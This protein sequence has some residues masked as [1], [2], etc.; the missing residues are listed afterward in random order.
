MKNLKR[1]LSLAL[2]GVMLS[3]MMVMGASAADFTD[4]DE[5][6]NANAVDTMVA[7][8]I[9]NGKDTGDFDPEGL[10][11][12]AEMAKM[13]TIALN[14]GID[15]VL[16]TK[17]TPTYTDIKGH[18]AEKYIEY[19]S[20]LGIINGRGN[21]AFDPA[22]TVTGTEAAKMVLVAMGYDSTVFK[23]TGADWAINVNT[24]ASN[25]TPYKLYEGIE[26][27]DPNAGLSRDNAAQII[28]NGVQ[29]YVMEKSPSLTIQNGQITYNYYKADGSNGSVAKTI[30]S[31]KYGASTWVGTYVGN[32]KTGDITTASAAKG[33]I[34]V[35]GWLNGITTNS[36]GTD[37]PADE[38]AFPSDMD[39]ANIGEEVKVIFKDSRNGKRNAPDK[40]DT[41]YGV[42]NTGATEVLNVTKGDIQ[43]NKAAEKK[44]KVDGTKY[45]LADTVTVYTN[46]AKKAVYTK[47]DKTNTIQGVKDKSN[48]KLTEN[49]MDKT[50]DTIKF[51]MND[52]GKIFA[53][54]VVESKLGVVTAKNSTKVTVN[55]VGTLT[56]ADH[57]IYD[58]IAVDDV[59]VTTVL[60]KTSATTDGAL[61]IVEEA[62][63]AT[64]DVDRYKDQTSVTIDGTVYKVY[65]GTDMTTTNLGSKAV[66]AFEGKH[67]GET[68]DLYLVNGYVAAAVQTSESASNYSLI[69]DKPDDGKTGSVFDNLRLQV[70]GADNVKTI[71]TVS[72]DSDLKTVGEYNIGDIITYTIDKSGE[73]VVTVESSV[74]T[75][76]TASYLK[77]TKA[78]N[79]T[80][81]ANDCVLF[82]T[83]KTEKN[84]QD[85]DVKSG[86]KAYNI[87]DLGD[88]NVG[89]GTKWNSLE[90]NGK[91]VAVY[92]DLGNA[93]TGATSSTVYGIVTSYDGTDK[94]DGSA[95]KVYAVGVDSTV[96]TLYMPADSTKIEKGDIVY[97]DPANDNVYADKDIT[98]ISDTVAP[99]KNG[100]GILV[101]FAENYNEDDETIS[102]FTG[103]KKDGDAFKGD[104]REVLA[105]A[106]DAKIYYVDQNGDIASEGGSAPT[107]DNVAPKRNV[108]LVYDT[109]KNDVK[110][111]KAMIIEVSGEK[112]IINDLPK[113]E[114]K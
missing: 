39:I 59:V 49:L 12:R 65:G 22:G 14:G 79:K 48:S 88:V 1:L 61:V 56:I 100:H 82:A 7:L 13:I 107:F 69:I 94:V 68:F 83:T 43:D 106:S 31:E 70:L 67:I 52:D 71:I 87:R 81:T 18:W 17:T 5:I 104:G 2:T 63:T 23:F 99:D 62:E 15:P 50:G 33:E 3:G 92:A 35:E 45:D 93:P 90:K 37:K 78:F 72:D 57:D 32:A 27:I 51:V 91:I 20:N 102:V 53:A 111:V 44:I 101:A 16:G 6:V 38:A 66:E 75:T 95:R 46:Y 30:L 8:N 108:V 29:D 86:Y 98:V 42:F 19:C 113:V 110:T 77:A 47:D 21:G 112:E 4:A 105:V 28:F 64:G 24:E 60:Y 11:T 114:A 9:I 25:A 76:G 26:A 41:I 58:D 97:F 54:Y 55:G 36:D 89:N 74:K 73:A 109:D 84:E 40:N 10:V 80:A 85:T 34:V 96:Y 103:L